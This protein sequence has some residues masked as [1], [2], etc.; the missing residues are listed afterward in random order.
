[1]L[2]NG[3]WVLKS[4]V[5]VYLLVIYCYIKHCPKRNDLNNA[6][7]L[8]D[9]FAGQEYGRSFP[10]HPLCLLTGCTRD[11][12][13]GPVVSSEVRLRKDLLPNSLSDCSPCWTKSDLVTFKHCPS[14]V[15][16]STRNPVPSPGSTVKIQRS[17]EWAYYHCKCPFPIYALLF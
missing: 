17:C 8:S 10:S 16:K 1:M 14:S 7:L 12:A 11:V 3:I 5:Q 2:K 15:L 9:F 13:P 6:H 4:M